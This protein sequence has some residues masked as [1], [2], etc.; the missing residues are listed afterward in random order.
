[1]QTQPFLHTR[2]HLQAG[3]PAS[4]KCYADRNVNSINCALWGW[5]QG[6]KIKDLLGR[7][8]ENVCR[9]NRNEVKLMDCLNISGETSWWKNFEDCTSARQ[10]MDQAAKKH[11]NLTSPD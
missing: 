10:C 4:D 2:T 8:Y 5:P 9:G 7:V 6:D 1:M 11:D 3:N